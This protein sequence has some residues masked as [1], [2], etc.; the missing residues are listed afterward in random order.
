MRL[1]RRY[2]D[3]VRRAQREQVDSNSFDLF[4]ADPDVSRQRTD[5]VWN[6]C[7]RWS[8]KSRPRVQQTSKSEFN[9]IV[10]L[11]SINKGQGTSRILT[12]DCGFSQELLAALYVIPVE[13]PTPTCEV[14]NRLP[15][16]EVKFTKPRPKSAKKIPLIKNGVTRWGRVRSSRVQTT[17][18]EVTNEQNNVV[19]VYVFDVRHSDG[20]GAQGD[21]G[22]VER[23]AGGSG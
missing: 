10:S 8:N 23:S 3:W 20:P 14:F 17:E 15:L 12:I 22:Y 21:A 18:R 11:G 1:R 9:W 2:R 5:A 13:G 19:G 7:D 6:R 16:S 4:L